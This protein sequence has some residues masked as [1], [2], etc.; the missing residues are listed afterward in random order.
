[1]IKKPPVQEQ[2]DRIVIGSLQAA[3]EAYGGSVTIAEFV[4][5]LEAL[6]KRALCINHNERLDSVV[7]LSLARLVREN[8]VVEEAVRGVRRYLF[9]PT[10]GPIRNKEVQRE[11][12]GTDAGRG[13]SATGLVKSRRQRVKDLH[14]DCVVSIGRAARSRDVELFCAR[15]RRDIDLTAREISADMKSLATSGDLVLV[16]VGQSD[17][18]RGLYY[19]PKGFEPEAYKPKDPVTWRDT[20]EK[21]FGEVW[22]AEEA[23]AKGAGRRRRGIAGDRIR[24]AAADAWDA[25]DPRFRPKDFRSTLI[26]LTEG[27]NP[28][29]RIVHRAGKWKKLFAPID[30]PDSDLDLTES[31]ATD[32]ERMVIAVER[33]WDR[34]R[35]PVVEGEVQK[36]IDADA[37]LT[38]ESGKR[39]SV[40]L[41]AWRPGFE[42]QSWVSRQ[43]FRV[44]RIG[45]HACYAPVA[46][47]EEALAWCAE[48][49]ARRKWDEVQRDMAASSG[50]I[51]SS[52]ALGRYLLNQA[53]AQT[54]LGHLRATAS[55]DRFDAGLREDASE[56]IARITTFL[57]TMRRPAVDCTIESLLPT[58]AEEVEIGWAWPTLTENVGHLNPNIA[59]HTR[60]SGLAGSRYASIKRIPNPQYKRR[61]DPIA[62]QAASFLFEQTDALLHSAIR[63]PGV[64]CRIHAGIAKKE[65]GRFRDERFVFPA[66]KSA[67]YKVRLAAISCL[68][69]LRADGADAV[70]LDAA[71]TDPDS[72]VRRAALWAYGFIGAADADQLAASVADS[73]ADQGVRR[74][75]QSLLNRDRKGWWY[76]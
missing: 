73:D 22:A 25:T 7:E 9:R 45:K 51:I 47:R 59:K 54:F 69:F 5:A 13:S 44:G 4:A 61:C 3:N 40:H 43:F 23:A 67:D 46:H 60:L 53:A 1:V 2:I 11:S 65:L 8:L 15:S 36:E 27:V 24:E 19:V 16:K 42:F 75:A 74:F 49:E 33:G 64:E 37:A 55:D 76:V 20:I 39:A 66:M 14:R 32:A 6:R 31:F 58:V 34:Y 35:H 56:L 21:V 28:A 63:S 18:H 52:V 41:N 57:P 68:A 48:K 50:Q 70:L 71:I 38:L 72:A 62:E 10:H 12:L 17:R 29:F 30:V 26:G